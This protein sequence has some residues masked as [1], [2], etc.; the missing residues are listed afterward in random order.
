MILRRILD[1]LV[2]SW[3]PRRRRTSGSGDTDREE[4]ESTGVMVWVADPVGWRVE[5]ASL[6][7]FVFLDMLGRE[8]L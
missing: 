1:G 4:E 8:G 7:L 5:V 3:A 6:W 2:V